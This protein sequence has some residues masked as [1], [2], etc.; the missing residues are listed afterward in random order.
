M[1][2]APETGEAL[3]LRRSGSFSEDFEMRLSVVNGR[4]GEAERIAS[5]VLLGAV[6]RDVTSFSRPFA[7]LE[8][9]VECALGVCAVTPAPA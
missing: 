4:V 5:S 7:P 8:N 6:F 2:R 1:A 9:E 3:R